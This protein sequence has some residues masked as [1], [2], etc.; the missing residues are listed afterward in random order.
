MDH[1][2]FPFDKVKTVSFKEL[3]VHS[4]D[5]KDHGYIPNRHSCR[6]ENHNPALTID[7]IPQEAKTLAIIVD[8]PDAPSGDWVHWVIW[9]IPPTRHVKVMEDR[10]TQ[11]RND[12]DTNTYSGPCP[13]S[14]THRYFFK[15]YALNCMLDLTAFAGKKELERAMGGHVIGFGELIGLFKH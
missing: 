5:F 7:H 4:P 10:G 14:G 1:H 6:G 12:F 9:N 2:L 8:D 15:V 13:P 3:E 11:G